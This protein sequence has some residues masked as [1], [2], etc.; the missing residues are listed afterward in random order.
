M[1]EYVS[2]H[3]DNEVSGAAILATLIA[4]GGDK[5]ETLAE[6]HGLDLSQE[7][8]HPVQIDLDILRELKETGD[9]SDMVSVGMEIPE[10]AEF[11]PDLNDIHQALAS[12]NIAYQMNN[13]GPDIGFYAYEKLGERSAKMTCRNPY[14]SDFDFGLIYA[15]VKRFRPADSQFIRVIR[16]DTI[17]NRKTGADTCI[18]TVEW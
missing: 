5:V 10:A 8:Y 14:P 2:F 13:R 6:K 1:V 7:G 11:P 17:P 9:F 15:M 12:I 18:Y 16:D 3:P 4:L